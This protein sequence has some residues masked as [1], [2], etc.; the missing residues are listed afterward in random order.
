[1]LVSPWRTIVGPACSRASSR[2]GER[3]RAGARSG[4]RSSGTRPSGCSIA[5][6]SS[7]I[8]GSAIEAAPPRAPSSS[9]AELHVGRELRDLH[10]RLG[11]ALGDALLAQ[12][13]VRARRDALSTGGPS[14]CDSRLASYSMFCSQ[15]ARSMRAQELAAALGRHRVAEL[16]VERVARRLAPLDA[17]REVLRRR[18]RPTSTDVDAARPSPATRSAS[19]R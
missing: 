2:A 16:G 18:S 14:R 15:S 13:L 1:M 3:G 10:L 17:G 12:R 6:A 9:V 4:A 7:L 5:A 11:R 19:R 8:G